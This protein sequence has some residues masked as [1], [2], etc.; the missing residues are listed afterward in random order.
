M[1]TGEVFLGTT[2]DDYYDKIMRTGVVNYEGWGGNYE[3]WQVK[4]EDWGGNYD[5]WGVANMRTGVEIMTT[6][7]WYIWGPGW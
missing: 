2:R 4:Y 7:G 3:D 6:E 5:D 1:R